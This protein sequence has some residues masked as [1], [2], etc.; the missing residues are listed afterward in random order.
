MRL[1]IAAF[2][3]S[4]AVTPAL[5]AGQQ[6]AKGRRAP[7]ASSE[8]GANTKT[9]RAILKVESQLR[10]AMTKC[11]VALLDRLLADYY[12]DSFEGTNDAVGKR[13]TLAR[14]KGGDIRYYSI[15]EERKISV[16]ADIVTVE[17]MTRSSAQTDGRESGREVSVKRLWTKK[18]GRWQLIAQTIGAGREE[19]E[20]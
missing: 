6:H 7:A 17:G 20:R 3:L 4:L 2:A 10:E 9:E 16:S 15:D 12:A 18:E 5:Q 8:P 19:S 13:G 11:N 1:L 14:C